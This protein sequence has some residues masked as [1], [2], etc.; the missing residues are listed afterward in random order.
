MTNK[1][2][3]YDTLGELLYAITKADGIIHEEQLTA[4]EEII[5]D[6]PWASNIKWSFNYELEHNHTVNDV[7]DKVISFCHGYGPT[8]EYEEFI[9]LM[10]KIAIANG[11]VDQREENLIK[12][13]TEDLTERFRADIE[14]LMN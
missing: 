10:N 8:A 13:F 9:D 12:S 3:L 6:H 2:R 1:E 14:K 11:F 7:Y 5:K 4:L